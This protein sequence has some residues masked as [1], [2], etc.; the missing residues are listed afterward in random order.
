MQYS[1]YLVAA[2][3]V[4][5]GF[6]AI[7]MARHE[8][9]LSATRMIR[10][11]EALDAEV[12]LEKYLA[13]DIRLLI[14]AQV[15]LPLAALSMIGLMVVIFPVE[16]PLSELGF[17]SLSCF[18]AMAAISATFAIACL[19]YINPP[20]LRREVRAWTSPLTSIPSA[21][22]Q[23]NTWVSE[24]PELSLL[25][26]KPRPLVMLDFL[27]ARD[28]VAQVE[29]VKAAYRNAGFAEAQLAA[30]KMACAEL[31]SRLGLN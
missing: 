31:H 17:Y 29:A 23:L 22:T 28:S 2:V 13:G 12:P 8:K 11:R 27:I 7:F 26:N 24:N 18:T 5:T 14:W 3:I 4:S 19:I 20:Y 15:L 1:L 6:A 16:R 10:A 21:C 30:D 9:A 25:P